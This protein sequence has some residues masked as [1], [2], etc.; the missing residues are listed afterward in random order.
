MRMAGTARQK[1]WCKGE[2]GHGRN[3]FY[4]FQDKDT[5]P[6]CLFFLYAQDDPFYDTIGPKKPRNLPEMAQ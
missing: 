5:R 3:A 6:L 1:E 4:A 2:K